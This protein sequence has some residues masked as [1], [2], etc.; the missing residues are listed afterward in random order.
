MSAWEASTLQA[1]FFFSGKS[2]SMY[3]VVCICSIFG[4]LT[5]NIPNIC[6]PQVDRG[7][8]GG[9]VVRGAGRNNGPVDNRLEE[10][11]PSEPVIASYN[12]FL[13]IL[14]TVR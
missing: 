8:G 14:A 7:G 10:S 3:K 2:F 6:L 11:N 9:G 5:N 4:R 12:G 13:F 1:E